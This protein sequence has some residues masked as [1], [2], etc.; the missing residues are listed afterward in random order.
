MQF[1]P[2]K[3]LARSVL[4][5]YVENVKSTRKNLSNVEQTGEQMRRLARTYCDDMAD[6]ASM[7][8]LDLFNYIKEIPYRKDPE[9]VE[10]LQRPLFLRLEAASGADCDD[11]AIAVAAWAICAKYHWRIVAVSR[12]PDH[13]LHHVFTEVL[14]GNQYIPID[15]TYSTSTFGRVDNW[16]FR[17]ILAMG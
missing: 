12:R 7:S 10:L 4:G 15:P 6:L 11:R 3:S 5:R 16:T 14:L 9:G 17:K 1:A 8:P 13:R 2:L